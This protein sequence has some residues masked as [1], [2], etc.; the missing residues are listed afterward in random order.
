MPQYQP[1]FEIVPILAYVQSLHTA[2]LST[3]IAIFQ[4]PVPN[5]LLLYFQG[6]QHGPPHTVSAGDK[7]QC[8]DSFSVSGEAGESWEGE[9]IL[10]NPQVS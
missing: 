4:S 1:T 6:E 8:G 9:R 10:P 7:G 3:A 5:C 2:S